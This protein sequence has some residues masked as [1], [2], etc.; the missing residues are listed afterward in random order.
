[1]CGVRDS[2][3]TKTKCMKSYKHKPKVENRK[4]EKKREHK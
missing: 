3:P 4:R 1:M 2:Q